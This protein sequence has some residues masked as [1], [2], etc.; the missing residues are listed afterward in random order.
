[1]LRNKYYIFQDSS[2]RISYILVYS[3]LVKNFKTDDILI[4]ASYKNNKIYMTK[5]E[6]LV[7]EYHDLFYNNDLRVKR[8]FKADY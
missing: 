1:M 5:Y 6:E 2:L 8:G 3:L 7:P 4:A